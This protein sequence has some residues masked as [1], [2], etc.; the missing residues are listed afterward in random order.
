MA[1]SGVSEGAHTY[2][3]K[4]TDAAGNASP[5]SNTVTV[6][7]DKTTPKV[8]SVN[9]ASGATKVARNTS[10]TVTFSE[11]IDSKTLVTTPTDPANPNVGT[12]TTFTLTKQGSTTPVTAKVS[13]D[14]ATKKV[15]LKASANLEARTKYT[16]KMSGV[17]DLAGNAL[18]AYTWSFTTGS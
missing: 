17:K 6:T 9:P 15:T 1:L 3:A 4:A 11:A 13:Y 8:S 12:S 2:S 18:T 7:V 10:V 5:A 16:V 14:T